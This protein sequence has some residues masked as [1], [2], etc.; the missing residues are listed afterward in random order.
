MATSFKA[1]ELA[2]NLAEELALRL[3][4][5]AVVSYSAVG[6]AAADAVFGDGATT[7]TLHPMITFGTAQSTGTACC[8][9]FVKPI[10]WVNAFDV[11]GLRS[12]VY[13]PH[14]IL[15]GIEGVSG[16]GAEPLSLIQKAQIAGIL[17]ARGCRIRV[18]SR[19]NGAAFGVADFVIANQRGVL[20]SS[21]KYPMVQSQ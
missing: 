20:E 13:T 14:E 1:Q 6:Q 4:L 18:F 5:P 2:K 17:A 7:A 15:W 16:G 19:A 12:N 11:L 8:L 10:E 3:A 9:I 21:A